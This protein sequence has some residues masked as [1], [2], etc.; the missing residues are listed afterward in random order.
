MRRTERAERP[1]WAYWAVA[2]VALVW[3]AFG[4]VDFTMTASR[5]PAYLSQMAPEVIDW[6]DSAPTWSMA[7]WGLG[8]GGG[9]A[10][11]LLL[12]LRS[13]LAL[14]AFALSL[15]GLALT[16]AWQFASPMPRVGTSSSASAMTALI[17]IVAV[18]LLWFAWR[19]RREGV[20][21]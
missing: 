11:A 6:L 20:L 19:K 8:V 18:A 3:N 16:Q 17:W 12:L 4:C 13:R 14:L 5:N 21:L 1:G 10:G 2:V 9:A 15:A 7:A